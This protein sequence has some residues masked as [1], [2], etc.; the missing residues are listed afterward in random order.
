VEIGYGNFTS[1]PLQVVAAGN[2]ADHRS[3]RQVSANFIET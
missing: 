3:D 2:V 1:Q